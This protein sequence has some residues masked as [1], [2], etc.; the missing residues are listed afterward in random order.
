MLAVSLPGDID[1]AQRRR[2]SQD[3]TLS[4]PRFLCIQKAQASEELSIQSRLCV[5]MSIQHGIYP[6]ESQEMDR[7]RK[8]LKTR[9][10]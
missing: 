10:L 1:Q 4:P 7:E 8:V 2:V 5:Q 6:F 3:G 9:G